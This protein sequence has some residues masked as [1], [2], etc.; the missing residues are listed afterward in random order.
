MAGANATNNFMKIG[1][2]IVILGLFVQL[3][4]FGTFVVL[5]TLFHRRLSHNPTPTS[6]RPEIRWR[7]YLLTLYVTSA[8][9]WIRYVFRVIEYVQGNDGYLMR[10]EVFVFCV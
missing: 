4:F 2:I 3:T 1:E 10:K 7:S 9:I 5:A 6:E 8:L